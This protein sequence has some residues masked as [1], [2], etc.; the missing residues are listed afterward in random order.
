MQLL[1]Y[2]LNSFGML[3]SMAISTRYEGL[4]CFVLQY[5]VKGYDMKHPLG[6]YNDAH[7]KS[8]IHVEFWLE[9]FMK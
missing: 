7:G 8:K 9:G 4:V 6:W 5:I 2:N 1:F 3:T